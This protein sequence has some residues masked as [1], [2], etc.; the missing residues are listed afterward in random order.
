VSITNRAT[1]TDGHRLHE[2]TQRPVR[3]ASGLLILE[4][5][6]PSKSAVRVHADVTGRGHLPCQ[7]AQGLCGHSGTIREQTVC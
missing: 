7:T 3:D 4:A 2:C 5:E 6:V 1:A